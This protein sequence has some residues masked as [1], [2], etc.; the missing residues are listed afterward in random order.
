VVDVSQLEVLLPHGFS[1]VFTLAFDATRRF[2]VLAALCLAV[3]VVGLDTTVLT[4]ALPTLSVD[5]GASTE[6]LQ[7]IANS[8]N[9]VLAALLLPAGLFGD[10]FGPKKMLAVALILF[11]AGS[12]VCALSDSASQL[13]AARAFLGIGAALLVVGA[14]V[15]IVFLP[16]HGKAVGP[17]DSM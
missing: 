9:L 15:S 4:V 14:V 10:R 6:Q 3:L 12:V 2:G 11:G 16:R 8:Y 5:L 7:W 17:T 1:L 13:I